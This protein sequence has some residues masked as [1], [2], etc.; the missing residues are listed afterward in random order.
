M[1]PSTS[2]SS[3]NTPTGSSHNGKDLGETLKI[4]SPG[5][6]DGGAGKLQGFLTQLRTYHRFFP[7]KLSNDTNK[8]L[9]AA[10]CLTGP[11]L[12]WFQPMLNDYLTKSPDD[13]DDGLLKVFAKYSSFERALKGAFGTVDEER[14]A[15][16]RIQELKQRGSTSDYA[17]T[18]RQVSAR[19]G[20]DDEPLMTVFYNGLKEEVKDELYK[21]TIPKTLAEYIA[22]AVRIDDRQHERRRQKQSKGPLPTWT[23]QKRNNNNRPN[24][25][26]TRQQPSTAWGRTTHAGPMELDAMRDKSKE[27]CH[28]CGK[29]G[30]YARECHQPK[31]W[32]PVAEGKRQVNTLTNTA[33]SGYDMS[34]HATLHWTA[35][36]DD[37]CSMHK[38]GKIQ[39]GWFPKEP[40]KT[41][42]MMNRRRRDAPRR[43]RSLI[44]N[45]LKKRT[46]KAFKEF[47]TPEPVTQES[48]STSQTIDR[49]PVR[50]VTPRELEEGENIPDAQPRVNIS[51][52][53]K[54]EDSDCSSLGDG[55][56]ITPGHDTPEGSCDDTSSEEDTNS[57]AYESAE[58]LSPKE[59]H[60]R[61]QDATLTRYQPMPKGGDHTVWI[62]AV[63]LKTAI[64]RLLW[65]PKKELNDH[66]WT[67]PSHRH[68]EE[69]SWAS[70]I[71]HLCTQHFKEKVEHGVFPIRIPGK[72]NAYPYLHEELKHWII[73]ATHPM[74][75][76]AILERDER[77]PLDCALGNTDTEECLDIGCKIHKNRKLRQYQQK[78]IEW[79]EKT[80]PDSR[81]KSNKCE[82]THAM[83]CGNRQCPQHALE[84]LKIYERIRKMSKEGFSFK[85]REGPNK[86]DQ[87]WYEE[88]R[89]HSDWHKSETVD[90]HATIET[91]DQ[92]P[93]GKS[94][95]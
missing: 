2:G 14:A 28:N 21:E 92:D 63:V 83:N 16:Q 62:R 88:I 58:E 57:D 1:S 95:L 73:L 51:D 49:I 43:P 8:V 65:E 6:F 60:R 69:L 37:K 75:S 26:R 29:Q 64:P 84:S 38:H 87:E 45:D 78:Q 72:A 61:Y 30:H 85:T 25:G 27:K 47:D 24:Q 80:E 66:P 41:L 70:C 76:T 67:F 4:D 18:F 13:L 23:Y 10:T 36:Y 11:A 40:R 32:K 15:I 91:K 82:A 89:K 9:H 81:T 5:P 56:K 12:A 34:A 46:E 90:E 52:L 42:A 94:R 71:Y 39:A 55:K 31:K 22:M 74:H 59:K 54:E 48:S 19:T 93:K 68:H 3:V 35:C 86:E 20:W 53:L 33:R 79:L 77:Y 7:G 50:T 44:D 17:A